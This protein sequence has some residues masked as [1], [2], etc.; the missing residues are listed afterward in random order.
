MPGRFHPDYYAV[1]LFSDMLSRG[2]SS[3]LFQQLVK[4]KE[5]FT[6]ISSFVTGTIDP[7]LFV[8][9]G[10]LQEGIELE[11]AE[12]EVDKIL[13][14]IGNDG[15]LL[16]ELEKVKNQ[17]EAVLEFGEVEIINRAMNL[18]FSSLSGNPDLVNQEA[19]KIR[20]VSA[21][22]IRRVSQEIVK[23]DRSNVMYYRRD[24]K[25]KL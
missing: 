7:G 22:D 16:D 8:V 11:Q 4:E 19:E 20:A 6:S 14:E 15:V 2:Q 1:D 17:A 24:V 9:S 13:A 5:I 10:R 12:S 25:L 21:E 3:R 23:E 18:A